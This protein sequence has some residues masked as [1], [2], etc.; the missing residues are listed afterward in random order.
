[1]FRPTQT[2]RAPTAAQVAARGR[3]RDFSDAE[4]VVLLSRD[5][6]S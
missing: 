1:V 3:V 6:P 2:E 5:K 4:A